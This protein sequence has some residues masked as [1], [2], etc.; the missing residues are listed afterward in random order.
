MKIG[1]IRTLM[2]NVAGTEWEMLIVLAGLYGL[3]MSECIGLRWHN[4]DLEGGSFAVVEQLPFQLPV[5]TNTVLEMAPVKS[6]ER[7]LPITAAVRP[8]FERQLAQQRRQK[9]LMTQ[10][11]QMYY[12]NDLVIFK[13]NGSPK[14]RERVSADFAQLLKRLH[15]PHIRFHDLRHSA[16]TDMHQLTGDF[17][18]VGVILGHNLKG[19]DNQLGV[20]GSLDA[21]TAQ[22]IDVRLDRKR[23]VLEAY[24]QAVLGDI[25]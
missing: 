12:A 8:Y 19:I 2:A 10:S 20:A 21:V 5:G 11:G 9:G 25:L 4:V 15:M 24:H 13:P 6:N 7:V 3:R 23:I 18:T 14:R 17:Y 22:Y 1:Y 16:A